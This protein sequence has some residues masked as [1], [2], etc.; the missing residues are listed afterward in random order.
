MQAQT[1][2][3][4]PR[5]DLTSNAKVDV[6]VNLAQ[7]QWLNVIRLNFT[8]QN[9]ASYSVSVS[10]GSNTQLVYSS[11]S[12]NPSGYAYYG[13][14][15]TF[16]TKQILFTLQGSSDATN[17]F[18]SRVEDMVAYVG[19]GY[20]SPNSDA[21]YNL[22]KV[23]GTSLGTT[24]LWSGA[25]LATVTDDRLG[26]RMS[27]SASA[28]THSVATF[29]LG[30]SYGA[31]GVH[32]EFYNSSWAYGGKVEIGTAGGTWTS[33]LDQST[34]LTTT[35]LDFTGQMV[36]YLRITDY[37]NPAGNGT[38]TGLLAELELI[39]DPAPEPATLALLAL[40]GMAMLRRRRR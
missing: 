6:T 16:A 4:S 7:A 35:F 18:F 31:K 30:G 24:G 13:F 33:L 38:G 36:R 12:T 22:L 5:T 10:D 25:S 15:P 37:K 14:T 29:D 9:S 23:A 17:G 19:S 8:S 34:S 28:T 32:L 39:G 1:I 2:S 26:T 11:L 3:L 21:G 40:G 27:G 20:A